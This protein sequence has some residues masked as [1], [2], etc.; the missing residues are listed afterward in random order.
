MFTK[1]KAWFVMLVSLLC[2]YLLDTMFFHNPSGIIIFLMNVLFVLLGF[3]L[4]QEK[5][6]YFVLPWLFL[7]LTLS[8]WLFIRDS[9]WLYFFN[10]VTPV[11]LAILFIANCRQESYQ[12][13]SYSLLLPFSLFFNLLGKVG[14]PLKSAFTYTDNKTTRIIKNV[15]LALPIILFI[16]L[17]LWSADLVWQKYFADLANWLQINEWE[18][19]KVWHILIILYFFFFCGLFSSIVYQTFKPLQFNLSE[20]S[21]SKNILRLIAIG[22]IVILAIFIATQIRFLFADASVVEALGIG[23]QDYAHQGFYQLMIVAIISFFTIWFL[24]KERTESR[25]DLVL[26]YILIA[27]TILLLISAMDRLWLFVTE[28]AWATRRFFAWEGMIFFIIILILFCIHLGYKKFNRS[29]FIY[30]FTILFSLNILLINIINPDKFI[31]RQN[32]DKYLNGG[33]EYEMD[34]DYTSYVSADAIQESL[35][36]FDH[37]RTEKEKQRA[38]WSLNRAWEILEYYHRQ[39][40]QHPEHY[41]YSKEEAYNILEPRMNEILLFQEIKL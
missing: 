36:L 17:L 41:H 4:W 37:A 24:T 16:T 23:Y 9:G 29:L 12:K 28:L 34:F 27:E 5:K 33:E 14:I 1:K 25:K 32:V 40:L 35:E 13:F 8:V 15:L 10:F 7:T 19:S 20:K 2:A 21:E 22:I 18:F 11:T 31:A 6:N 26:S 38:G 30:I 3:Y 39:Q